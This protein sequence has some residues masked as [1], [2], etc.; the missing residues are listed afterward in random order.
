V[1]ELEFCV[2]GPL[3]V[4]SGGVVVP[5][6]QARSRAVLA[7]LLLSAGRPVPVDD[8]AE[9]LWGSGRPPSAAVSLRNYVMRLGVVWAGR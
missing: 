3:L 6:T 1:A 8:L 7:V 2:L 5:V 9:V 4:R